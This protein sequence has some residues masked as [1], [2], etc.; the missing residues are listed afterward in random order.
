MAKEFFWNVWLRLN[1]LTKDIE[2]D[3]VAEVQPSGPTVKNEEIARRIV[4]ERSEYRQETIVNVLTMRDE[5]ERRGDAGYAQVRGEHAEE[6]HLPR[7]RA[8]GRDVHAQG[9]NALFRVPAFAQR[10]AYHNVRAS[11]DQCTRLVQSRKQSGR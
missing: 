4:A 10:A 8:G 3:R 6:A 7:A 11:I 9:R 2:I 5:S 1:P